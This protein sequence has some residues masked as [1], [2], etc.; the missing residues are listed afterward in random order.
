MPQNIPQSEKSATIYIKKSA[1]ER[2][3]IPALI[4]QTLTEQNFRKRE[5]NKGGYLCRTLHP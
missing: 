1:K 4:R 2:R 3:T 5:K